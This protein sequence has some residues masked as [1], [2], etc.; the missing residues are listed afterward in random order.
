MNKDNWICK[1]LIMCE[2]IKLK[3]YRYYKMNSKNLNG[4]YM[5]IFSKNKHLNLKDISMHYYKNY[6]NKYQN[7]SKMSYPSTDC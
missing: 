3:D 7:K 4:A 1:H 6:T 2:N 5:A